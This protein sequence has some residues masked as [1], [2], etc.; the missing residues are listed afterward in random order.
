[1]MEIQ[2]IY[3]DDHSNATWGL[4]SYLDKK[5]IPEAGSSLEELDEEDVIELV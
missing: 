5:D 4:E 3:R 2:E 1:M